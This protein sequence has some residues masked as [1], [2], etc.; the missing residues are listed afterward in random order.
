MGKD[1]PKQPAPPDP[2]ATANAQAAANTQAAVTQAGLNR[3]NQVTPQGSLTYSQHGTDANGIPQYTQTQTYSP[4]QQALYTQQNQIAQA[5]GGLAGNNIQRVG[6]AQGQDFNF[7]GFAPLQFGAGGGP[8]QYGSPGNFQATT[9]VQ[10]TG[11]VQMGYDQGGGIQ[12]T[13]GTGG[14]L[15]SNVGPSQ[16]QTGLNYGGTFNPGDFNQTVKA[17]ADAQYSQAASRLDPQFTQQQNDLIA[18]LQNSGIAVGSDAYNREMDNFGRTRTDAYNQ[19]AYSAQAAG[20]AAQQQGYG[21]SLNTRAQQVGETT[22]AGEFGNRAAGQIFGMD[23]SNANLNNTAQGQQYQQ[24]LGAAQFGNQSQ[25]QQNT[26]NREQ[27]MFGNAAQ[28]QAYQQA[29]ANAGFYNQGQGQNFGQGQQAAALWNTTQNQAF[30][31]NAANATMNNQGRQQQIDEATYLRNLPLNDIA[32]LLGTGGGVQQPQFNPFAQVGVAAPDYQG[33]VYANYNAA[34]QQYQQAQQNRSG[35]LGSIFGLAGTLGAAAISDRRFKANIRR[36]G[37][38]ASGLKTYVFNYI[39]DATTRFG[40]MAQDAM[41]VLP[42][43]VGVL[44]SG[45]LYVDY[46]KVW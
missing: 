21:Q 17:A 29:L 9:Q 7:N 13:F 46:R 32:T 28:D 1:T 27:S 15:T 26:Q 22:T 36:V 18:R 45:V 37:T 42:E 30:N 33:A 3:I 35:G 4:E 41:N 20:L 6:Q 44:P 14:P 2:V 31:Q 43:A 40:V 5:L 23:M 19:A 34:N 8:L 39:G 10:D 25:Q 11:A 24:N 38:L 16:V 12:S